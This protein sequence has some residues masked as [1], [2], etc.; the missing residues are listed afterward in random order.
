MNETKVVRIRR[1]GGV[2]VQNCDVYI[3]RRFTMGQWDL[4][5]SIWANP[6]KVKEYGSEEKV[7][8]LYETYMRER[9]NK[10]PT[11]REQLQLLKGKTLGCW[12]K[13]KM[14]HGDILV[15]L[16]KEYC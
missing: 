9:L 10:E 13:P 2:I 4:P 5:E 6:Y 8:E 14:C 3:G 7:C 1:Q 16:I 12:C 11:L 15:K